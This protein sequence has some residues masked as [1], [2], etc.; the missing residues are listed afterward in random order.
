VEPAQEHAEQFWLFGAD[1]RVA[2]LL[3][4][5]DAL[6]ADLAQRIYACTRYDQPKD[7]PDDRLDPAPD[8]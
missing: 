8:C 4:I 7:D 6:L 5:G 3:A 2:E 1:P